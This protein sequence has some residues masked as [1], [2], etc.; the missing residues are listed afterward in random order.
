[1]EVCRKSCNQY[2]VSEGISGSQ[3]YLVRR[4]TG[5]DNTYI[6]IDPVG[7]LFGF[8]VEAGNKKQVLGAEVKIPA[9]LLIQQ[10]GEVENI[11]AE[12]DPVVLIEFKILCQ[13]YIKSS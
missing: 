7:V 13:S 9:P 8:L 2:L 10:I 3:L 11:N 1:M 12:S 5:V 4:T 6:F